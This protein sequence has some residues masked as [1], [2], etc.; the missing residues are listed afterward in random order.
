MGPKGLGILS[1]VSCKYLGMGY[2]WKIEYSMGLRL[3]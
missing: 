1:G 2:R 3:M